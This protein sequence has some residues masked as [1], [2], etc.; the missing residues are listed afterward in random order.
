MD[1]KEW[2]KCKITGSK[3][4][5]GNGKVLFVFCIVTFFK[6]LVIFVIAVSVKKHNF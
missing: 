3:R 2:S 4:N 1:K 6:E 5:G